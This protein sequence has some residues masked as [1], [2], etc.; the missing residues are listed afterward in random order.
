M[1]YKVE[2]GIPIHG[3]HG[4]QKYPFHEM[5]VGDSFFVPI[6]DGSRE[7]NMRRLWASC[8]HAEK[9]LGYKFIVRAVKKSHGD[10]DDGFRVWR[11]S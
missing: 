11:I 5:E 3:Y 10:P 1:K 8:A 9:D 7:V 6:E 4:N 2:K